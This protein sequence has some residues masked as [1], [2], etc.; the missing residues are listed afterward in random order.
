MITRRVL[1]GDRVEVTF[2][3]LNLGQSLPVTLVGDFNGWDPVALE[4]AGNG[5]GELSATLV[6]P[7]GRRYE[8]RY[9]DSGGRWFN[10]E[11][12]DDYCETPVGAVNGVLL[13]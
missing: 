5:N 4:L 1:E 3:V 12:A 7:R 8:F 13:T 2:C 9:R 6:V 11:A 10:D